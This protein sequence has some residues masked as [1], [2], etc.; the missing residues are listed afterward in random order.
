MGFRPFVW[1]LAQRFNLAGDVCNDGHGVLIRLSDDS[2]LSAFIAELQQKA[3][4]LAR[5]EQID[6]EFFNWPDAPGQFCI[7]DNVSSSMQTQVSADAATCPDCL[8]ELFSPDNRR[9]RYPFINCT[10]CGPRISLIHAMPYQRAATSMA[11]FPLCPTCEHEYSSPADRRFHAEPNACPDCG[12][13]LCWRKPD[14]T[15]SYYGEDALN[16]AEAA[17]KAGQV[18]AVKGLGGFHL[19]CDAQNDT[20][21]ALLR[22]RKHRPAKP[23]AVMVPSVDW[24]PK[25][26]QQSAVAHA[27]EKLTE[28]ANPIVL[29][30]MRPDA[31]LSKWIAPGLI[32]VGLL[33][34]GNPIQHL[35]AADLARPLVMTSA[36]GSGM[37]PPLDDDQLIAELASLVDGVLG[38][39]RAIVTRMDDSVWRQANVPYVI[40]RS[41][42]YVPQSLPVRTPAD[43][44][45]LALGGDLKNTF[46]LLRGDRV[47][48]SGHYGDLG[49]LSV[50]QQWQQG[51]RHYLHLYQFQPQ[52]IAVDAHPDYHV[53]RLAEELACE[54]K[55]PLCPVYH[56]HAHIL[57]AV[58]EAGW[59]PLQQVVGLSLDGLGWGEQ[60]ALWGG[61]C[62]VANAQ[63]F[64]HIG[65]L[66]AVALPGG[67]RAAKQPWR[68]LL[69]QWLAFVPNWQHYWPKHLN[70]Q[71][72][73]LLARA[74][75]R[76]IQSPLASSTGRLFDAVA[77][78]LNVAPLEL[79]FEGQA[80]MQ[81]EQLALSATVSRGLHLTMPLKAVDDKWQLDLAR[82]WQQWLSFNG[83]RAVKAWLFHEALADGFSQLARLVCGQCGL[84]R[85]VVTGG[86]LNNRL[87]R[88]LF[89]EKLEGF[90]LFIPHQFPAGDGALALGQAIIAAHTKVA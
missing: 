48:L 25:I 68:N 26:L 44:H 2:C 19:V 87:L 12:P 52:Q 13:T 17:I 33:L 83:D 36:N 41:R 46:G 22:T 39:D 59:D 66:P 89:T 72:T 18:I 1:H 47:I 75:E 30:P 50:Q 14:E 69:S 74:I 61:E 24:L 65:G 85:I 56:H 4:P 23:L 82:F 9:Y 73:S 63:G 67:D 7:R 64:T 84:K 55:V 40:R 20:A 62:L 15:D 21:V 88:Q 76:Q 8:K 49:E 37:A 79:A 34:P 86:G 53:H 77:C 45:I 58:A 3:P 32:E 16:A 60:G 54:L 70:Q 38:H 6:S 27:R 31:L 42:G 90:E 29:A 28:V 10:H 57:A 80:A 81:L 5:V 35:L 71:P 43:H 11:D 78:A 51:I